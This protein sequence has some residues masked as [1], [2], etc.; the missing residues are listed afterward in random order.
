M[1]QFAHKA[2]LP[3]RDLAW[4]DFPSFSGQDPTISDDS[5]QVKSIPFC[6]VFWKRRT[7]VTMII[8][9]RIRS[10]FHL[11]RNRCTIHISLSL[12]LSLSIY[13]YIYIYT[14]TTQTSI[15]CWSHPLKMKRWSSQKMRTAAEANGPCRSRS[16]S[17][18]PGHGVECLSPRFWNQVLRSKSVNPWLTFHEPILKHSHHSKT[19]C[20][21]T[22]Y[23]NPTPLST[24]HPDEVNG[25]SKIS[26][27]S[28]DLRNPLLET[29]K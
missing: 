9:N 26:I 17:N 20:P 15:A 25:C 12:S 23:P 4:G 1:V 8:Q 27:L 18:K 7:L 28:K 21:T 11:P 24:P 3:W 14:Y 2:G 6:F 19:F 29:Y 10:T 22:K 16:S 13:I 5:N